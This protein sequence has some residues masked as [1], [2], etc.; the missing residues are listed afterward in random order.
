MDNPKT[1]TAAFG[2]WTATALV[3]GNMIGSGILLLPS[4]LANYG[5]I[6]IIGWIFTTTGALFLSYVFMNLTRRFPNIGGPYVF[7]RRAF[8]DR[9]GFTVAYSYWI[10]IICGN[11]AIAI[12][13]TGYLSVFIPLIGASHFASLSASLI[14]LWGLTLVN[15]LGI[16]VSSKVQLVTALLKV[17]LLLAVACAGLFNFD[18]AHFAPF[19]Q[20]GE[21]DLGAITSTA[22]LTLWAFLGLESATIPADKIRN[23]EK[24]IP[25]ATI[26]GTV[27][28]AIVYILITVSIMGLL[29]PG[30][31]SR[32]NAPFADAITVIL[33]P[34]AGFTT[35]LIGVITCAGALNGWIFLQ[36]QMPLA[37]AMDDL[38]PKLFGKLSTRETPIGGIVFSS[39]LISLLLIMNYSA[40]LVEQ[41]TFI[42]LLATL[43]TLLPY[44][45]SA[46]A[47]FKFDVSDQARRPI[48]R[49]VIVT[50]LAF[51]YSWWAVLGL[52]MEAIAWGIV[53]ILTGAPLYWVIKV[54]KRE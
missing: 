18:P 27:T 36:G 2:F 7:A 12:A 10:S 34:A 30:E 9:A 20:S 13:L 15:V 48:I 29:S 28:V 14:C 33:G 24:N 46:L 51:I 42:I 44:L 40:A 41:F 37:A 47:Q 16:Q 31:L 5:G 52:G 38:F 1:S 17:M 54:R 53:C 50:S 11:A 8:G 45:I 4:A 21:S 35:A 19:N 6:S 22:A 23:P 39:C 3:V 26:L 25:R 49:S 32:S 43:A